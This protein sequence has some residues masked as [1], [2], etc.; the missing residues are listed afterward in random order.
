[1]CSHRIEIHSLEDLTPEVIDWMRKAY[2][3]AG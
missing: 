3:D 2:E 1:M